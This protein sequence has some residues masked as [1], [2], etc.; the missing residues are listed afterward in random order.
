[1]LVILLGI[2]QNQTM[3]SVIPFR[4]FVTVMFYKLLESV[5]NTIQVLEIYGECFQGPCSHC[6]EDSYNEFCA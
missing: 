5:C 1:M 6:H 3:N 4:K 2:R